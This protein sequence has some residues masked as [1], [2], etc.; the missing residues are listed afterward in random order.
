[1]Y[2]Y[3]EITL[4][5]LGMHQITSVIRVKSVTNAFNDAPGQRKVN[6]IYLCHQASTADICLSRDKKHMETICHIQHEH[7]T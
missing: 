2:S 3:I 4:N 6:Y 7:T 5:T 1:M